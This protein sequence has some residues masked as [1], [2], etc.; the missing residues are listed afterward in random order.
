[1]SLTLREVR[2]GDRVTLTVHGGLNLDGTS[3]RKT[4]SGRAVIVNSFPMDPA[5]DSVVVNIGGRYGTPAVATGDN[6]VRASKGRNRKPATA[7]AIEALLR[8]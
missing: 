2:P 8:Q 5:R 3:D 4:V 1:M 7:P 6:F